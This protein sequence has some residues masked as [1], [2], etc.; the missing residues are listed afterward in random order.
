MSMLNGYFDCFC[1]VVWISH[2]GICFSFCYVQN[3]EKITIKRFTERKNLCKIKPLLKS[4]S[5]SPHP[6]AWFFCACRIR[7]TMP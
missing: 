3:A 6:K 2:G 4:I 7:S 1:Q 5:G